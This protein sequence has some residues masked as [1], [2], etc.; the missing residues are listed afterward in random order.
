M[1][2]KWVWANDDKHYLLNKGNSKLWQEFKNNKVV[3]NYTVK[4]ES[5]AKGGLILY[6]QALKQ[7]ARV[8]D[9]RIIFHNNLDKIKEGKYTKKAIGH[10]LIKPGTSTSTSTPRKSK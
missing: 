5:N 6:N 10:W 9:H 7:Y 3:S 2:G 8:L 1:T 4:R